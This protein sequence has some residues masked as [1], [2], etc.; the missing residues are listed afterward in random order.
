[1][2]IFEQNMVGLCTNTILVNKNWNSNFE[3]IWNFLKMRGESLFIR[4]YFGI[5]KKN[6]T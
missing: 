5:S 2:S 1:M 3:D 4:N 6:P